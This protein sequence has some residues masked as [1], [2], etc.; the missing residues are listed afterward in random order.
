MTGDA[1]ALETSASTT[2]NGHCGTNMGSGA[3]PLIEAQVERD[4]K[5]WSARVRYD[6]DGGPP[7]KAEWLSEVEGSM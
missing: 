5:N 6:W 4:S 1:R 7:R 2:E 3:T